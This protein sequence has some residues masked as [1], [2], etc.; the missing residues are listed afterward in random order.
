MLIAKLRRNT[1]PTIK[2]SG[3]EPFW[4]SLKKNIKRVERK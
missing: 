3:I 4:E 2:D 1:Q